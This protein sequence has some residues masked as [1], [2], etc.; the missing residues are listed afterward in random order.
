MSHSYSNNYVHVIYSTKG[1]ENLIPED[2]EKRLYS[3]IASVARK[4]EMPLLAAGGIAN[5][6]HLLFVLPANM[7]LA[8]AINTF[9]ANSS[10]FMH[11]QSLD[12]PMAER[13]R[14]L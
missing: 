13:I 6:S 3:F 14:S 10:R 4:H 11:E 5:H 7:T 1:R 9:K 8:S 12:F 2:F